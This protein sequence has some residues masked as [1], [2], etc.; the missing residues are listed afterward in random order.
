MP[1]VPLHPCVRRRFALNLGARATLHAYHSDRVEVN[2]ESS[3]RR[4]VRRDLF[5]H[6]QGGNRFAHEVLNMR[7]ALRIVNRQG[8]CRAI[9]DQRLFFAAKLGVEIATRQLEK[10][11]GW[12]FLKQRSDYGERFLILLIVAV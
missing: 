2:A 8:A 12:I 1:S 9:T 7:L 6:T 5:L 11:V 10:R 3:G 4:S